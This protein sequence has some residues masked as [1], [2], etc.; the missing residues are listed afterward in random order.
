MHGIALRFWLLV[1]LLLC[2]VLLAGAGIEARLAYLDSIEAAE[3]AQRLEARAAG[4]RISQYLGTI[5][6][7]IRDAATLAWGSGALSTADLQE[8]FHRVMKLVPA[9]SEMRNIDSRGRERLY[10]SRTDKDRVDSRSYVSEDIVK[11]A[12]MA[13]VV[14]GPVTFHE[15]ARPFASIAVRE[16]DHRPSGVSIAELD[17]KFVTDVVQGIAIGETGNAYVVDRENRLVA[18]PNLSLVLRETNLA[19]L[20][21][22]AAAREALAESPDAALPTRWSQAID[23][24]GVLV[25]AVH[26]AGPDWLLF[27]EEPEDEALAPVRKI[28]YRN[29]ALLIAGIIVAF[30][31]SRLLAGALTRPILRLREGAIRLA[32]GRLDA[33]IDVKTG[34]EIESLAQEFN[35]MAEQLEESYSGLE[36]KV[37]ERTRELASARD[38]V[39]R[40]ARELAMLNEEL[41]AKVG[42]LGVRKDEAEKANAAKTRFLASASHDLRQPLHTI[43]L[44][45]GILRDHTRNDD[46]RDLAGKV[47]ASV[48]V[49]QN[50]FGS[51]LDISKLDAGAIRPGIIDFQVHDVLDRVEA[52][53]GPQAAEKRLA[54]RLRTSRAAVRSD[55][56]VLERILGNLITNAIRYTDRGKIL[57][58]CRRS[59]EKLRILVLDTGIGIAAD[60]LAIVFEEFVQLAN[61]ERDRT[62]GL[63]LGLSIVKR[64]AELLGHALIVR[65]TLGRGSVFGVEVPLSRDIP[66]TA[67]AEFEAF[68]HTGSLQ[69]AFVIVIDDDHASRTATETLFRHWGCHVAVAGS[70][71]EAMRALDA[72]L[73]APDLIVTDYRLRDG[74][75][76]IDAV[77]R[78]RTQTEQTVPAVVVTGDVSA[79]VLD[80]LRLPAFALLHKPVDVDTLLRTAGALLDAHLSDR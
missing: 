33:R 28:L 67:R 44:L 40:Q 36:A 10:V 9:I 23:G 79:P 45:A 19:G 52:N 30:L 54:F 38:Q 8:E 63:G 34:D 35:R 51:L 26:I 1:S 4:D 58:G 53:Y 39:Q 11:R 25:S 37:A 49:M 64:S 13:P 46:A 57:I 66:V 73:R 15:G 78:I 50:L 20:P 69:G 21:H 16:S 61:P 18:H 2:G 47:E 56:I 27:A 3:R 55:P 29:G 7:Q 48:A 59:G 5:E 77:C 72:H 70:P 32:G 62:K 71:D 60:D 68:P 24:R 75:T 42:E 43:G 74:K 22:V 6:S 17:L 31:A 41:T 80:R 65:S 76:G 14:Y 12:Q